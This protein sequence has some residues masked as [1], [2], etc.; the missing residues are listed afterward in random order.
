MWGRDQKYT[1]I[2]NEIN[3][4]REE[5]GG[6][7]GGNMSG[8]QCGCMYSVARRGGMN[9]CTARWTQANLFS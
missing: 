3:G 9:S 7:R 8:P 4:L 5:E 2:S 6:Q 1:A